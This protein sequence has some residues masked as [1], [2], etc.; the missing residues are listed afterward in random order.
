MPLLQLLSESAE[1]DE[2]K[3]IY[4]IYD[5]SHAVARDVYTHRVISTTT[6]RK[7]RINA[8]TVAVSMRDKARFFIRDR[9][10]LL[11]SLSYVLP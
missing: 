7:R 1:K 2:H 8:S 3:L 5:Y 6:V 4:D 10:S 11:T 9:P